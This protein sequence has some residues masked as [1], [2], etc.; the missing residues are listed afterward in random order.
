MQKRGTRSLPTEKVSL[1][2]T[3]TVVAPLYT[4]NNKKYLEFKM[5]RA[6]AGIIKE[7]HI[8]VQ[9]ALV[10]AKVQNPLVGDVLRVKVPW[11]GRNH[12]CK[13]TGNKSL[14]GLVEGDKV[15]IEVDFCGA[16]IVG[17]FSG[18]SWKLVSLEG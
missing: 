9:D 16:W 4:H 13:V 10:T 8:S 7:A 6:A 2:T 1:S 17:D 15:K 5:S 18:T 11:K 12:I 3:A 14:C